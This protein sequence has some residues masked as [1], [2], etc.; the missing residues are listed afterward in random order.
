ML[1]SFGVE[2][3]T[4]TMVNG[5]PKYTDLIMKNPDKLSVGEAMAKY[6]RVAA[7]SPGLVGDDRYID[8]YYPL[9]SQKDAS[10]I[11]S[12]HQKNATAVQ[13][14]RVTP[15]VTEASELSTI[16]SEVNTYQSEM[17]L[18]FVM[19][20]EPLANF[21]K[22]I[23]QMKALKIERAITIQQNALDQYNKRK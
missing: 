12:R 9:Q 7:P 22:Y 4:Y 13:L 10:V 21:D 3:V 14:P 20:V 1:K 5:Y 8:Q 16:L 2:G 23:A 19:G 18:K 6:M 15:S 17:F 11:F